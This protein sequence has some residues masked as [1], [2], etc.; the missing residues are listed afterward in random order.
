MFYIF[1]DIILKLFA[2][3][4]ITENANKNPIKKKPLP[5][6]SFF[7]KICYRV[8]VLMGDKG[9]RRRKSTP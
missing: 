7:L 4:V 1:N 8:H 6:L 5:F 3:R 9:G 2:F